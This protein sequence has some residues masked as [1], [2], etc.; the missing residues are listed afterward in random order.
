MTAHQA[1]VAAS[2]PRRRPGWAVIARKEFADHILSIR[3]VALL[4]LLGLVAVGSVYTAADALRDIAPETSGIERMFL[5]LFTVRADPIPFSFLTFLGF[6]PYWGSRS[7]S[8]R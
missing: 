2:W 3:F 8:T 1:T 6:L 5:R 7:G 4:I